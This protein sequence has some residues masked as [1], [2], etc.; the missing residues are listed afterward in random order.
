[1]SSQG[2]QLIVGLGNPGS[3]YEHTRHNVGIWFVEMLAN[4]ANVNL[5]QESKYLGKHA[6][7]TLDG[8]KCHLLTP[9]T[10]M[11]HSGQSVK[12][13]TNY[14]KI[15]P[16]AILVVHDELDLPVGTVRLKLDGGDG[17]HNGL[18]DIIRHLH[19]KQ[20]YR[21]RVGIGRPKPGG[22]VSDYVLNA[23]GKAERKEIEFS[24][25][26]A[27]TVLPLILHGHMSKAMQALHTSATDNNL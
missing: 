2:I 16:T 24:L 12:A 13:F 27:E 23:P 5:R 14:Y 25:S 18:K 6:I 21:L 11:N 22:D 10:F 1:M 15:E 20:F 19:T 3:E 7:A 26:Q 17:G 9:T 8:R 4:Q